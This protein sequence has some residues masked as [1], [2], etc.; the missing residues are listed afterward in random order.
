MKELQ[1]W[2]ISVSSSISLKMSR[3]SLLQNQR[4]FTTLR[5]LLWSV[6]LLLFFLG[7]FFEKV[8]SSFVLTL[9][10]FCL[11]S[12]NGQAYCRLEAYDYHASATVRSMLS[13]SDHLLDFL[14]LSLKSREN[15]EIAIGLVLQ[16][17]LK[18]Y[19]SRFLVLLPGNWPLQ[20][21]L[22]K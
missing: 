9:P 13:F 21:S 8:S 17:Y 5:V 6:K 20:F 4:R 7:H 11:R 19:L 2:T 15:Y 10:E 18:K 22:I 14:K 3:P 16:S 12:I 1:W